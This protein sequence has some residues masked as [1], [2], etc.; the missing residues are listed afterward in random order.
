MVLDKKTLEVKNV[1]AFCEKN[2]VFQVITSLIGNNFDI[3]LKLTTY[4]MEEF[5]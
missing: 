2:F 4:T 5:F 3:Y 1:F